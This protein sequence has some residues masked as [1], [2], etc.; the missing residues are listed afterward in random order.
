M[1]DNENL[2]DKIKELLGKEPENLNIL[3]ENIDVDLQVEYFEYS[4]RVAQEYDSSIA[5]DQKMLLED[6][7]YPI[8]SKKLLLTQ[9]ANLDDVSAYRA[10]E[11]YV[12]NPD[13]GLRDWSRLALQESRMHVESFLL[14]ESQIIISTGLGGKDGKLRYF[15]ALIARNMQE[16]SEFEIKVIKDEFSF[17]LS[18]YGAEIEEFNASGYLASLVLLLPIQFAVQEVFNEGI[19]ECNQYGDFL[20]DI[21]IVTNVKKLSFQEITNFIEKKSP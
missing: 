10:I 14:G 2:Y 3:E 4:K 6:P 7:D 1:R 13:K 15:V 8:E 9:L 21:C 18:R 17:M 19:A 11:S 16:L 12:N 20:R 5:L